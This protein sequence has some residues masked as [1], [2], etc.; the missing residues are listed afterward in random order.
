MTVL[1]PVILLIENDEGDVFLFRRALAKQE[2]Q[3][4]VR[5][6]STIPEAQRY[7]THCDEFTSKDYYP[8]P[9]LIVADMNLRGRLGTELLGWMRQRPELMRIPFVFLS[10]SFVPKEKAKALELGANGFYV[11]TANIEQTAQN[12]TTILRMLSEN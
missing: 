3:G 7:L 11:K 8:S 10:G 4:T 9:D 5:V 2:F 12:V 1:R 6:I